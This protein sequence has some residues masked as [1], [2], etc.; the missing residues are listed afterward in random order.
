MAE[1]L[2]GETTLPGGRKISRR[3]LLIPAAAALG[4]VAWRWYSASQDSSADETAVSDGTY[5]SD[6]MS[7]YGLSTTGGTGVVTGNNGVID[8]DGTD[9]NAINDN[10]QWT[11]RAVDLLSESGY[12]SMTVSAALGEFLARRSLDPS[13]AAIARAAM[14]RA[15]EP[16]VGRP[17]SVREEST[18]GGTGT[19]PAPTGL[20]VTKSD[21][22][23]ITI[24]W[25][26]VDGAA[27]YR[28]Y[29][30]TG[31]NVG[32]SVDTTGVFSGLQPDTSYPLSVAAVGTT[33]KIGT[34]SATLTAKTG[35]ITLGK[36]GHLRASSI[37]RSSFRVTCDPVKGAQGYRWYVNGAARGAS[38]QPY[39]DF[40]GMSPNH[41]YKITVRADVSTQKPG[42]ESSALTVK[43][44]K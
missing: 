25:D 8:T 23:S 29:R 9:P 20:K 37:T 10:A 35:R 1:F 30:G 7:E 36:P 6:D 31:D 27:M 16:P 21:A 19:L 33:G 2:E 39:R 11:N 44:K 5:S 24:T 17:W 40:T 32:V 12:D 4:Y 41:S 3:L 28:L 18:T 26:R 38:D 13:E 42:P 43:T 34:R 15:G 14:A 22:D